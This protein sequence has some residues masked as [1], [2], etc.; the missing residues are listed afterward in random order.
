MAQ[1]GLERQHFVNPRWGDICKHFDSH[2][3]VCV[4]VIERY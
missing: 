1:L 4:E 3:S 2:V